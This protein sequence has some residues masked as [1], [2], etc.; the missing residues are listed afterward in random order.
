MEKDRMMKVLQGQ[1]QELMRNE[2]HLST[3]ISSVHEDSL[4]FFGGKPF[5]P[6]DFQWPR[7]TLDDDLPLAFLGQLNL[8]DVAPF[9]TEGLLPRQGI[10]SFFYEL[11]TME[12]GSS[13]ELRDCFRV[14]Y[15]SEPVLLVPAVFPQDLDEAYQLPR[16]PVSFT[17]R[18]SLPSWEE[19]ADLVPEP[20]DPQVLVDGA[21]S[22]YN[23]VC[24]ELLGYDRQDGNKCKPLGYAN[25][26]QDSM[27]MECQLVSA[28]FETGNGPVPLDDSQRQQM[29]VAAKDWILLFQMDSLSE[30]VF[31]QTG[32]F[33]LMFGDCGRL[34]F[35]IRR[36]DLAAGRFDC[37]QL[38]LQC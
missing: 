29:K 9:D 15:F 33:E 30:G 20:L 5:L 36:E 37:C 24:Q 6:A 14:F 28:G 16:A 26:I 35:Y 4:S 10:L 12:W 34:F 38:V 32:D 19:Y 27:Q 1:L 31:P 22:I 17:S 8:A 2:S 23:K 7:Y 13:P 3:K 21:D 25:V 18:K 11:D